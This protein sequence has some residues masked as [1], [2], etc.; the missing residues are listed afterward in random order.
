MTMVV[1]A[2]EIVV[3]LTRIVVLDLIT[4]IH[5]FVVGNVAGDNLI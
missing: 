5:M 1:N 2:K 4:C 3:E